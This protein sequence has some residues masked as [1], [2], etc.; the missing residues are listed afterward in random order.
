MPGAPP[1]RGLPQGAFA[2]TQGSLYDDI[3]GGG[4]GEGYEGDFD[5]NPYGEIEGGFDAQ[6]QGYHNE[7]PHVRRI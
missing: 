1:K 5:E 4:G 6:S 3:P 7:T 2:N